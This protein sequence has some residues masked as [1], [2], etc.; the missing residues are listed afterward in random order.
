MSAPITPIDLSGGWADVSALLQLLKDP[1]ASQ[2]KLD[3]LV[4][5][6]NATK[7]RIAELHAM[8]AET[9]RLHNTAKATNIV[10]ENRKAALDA[11]E[12]E[13]E[14]RATQ[15]EQSESRH[16]AAS[17]QRRENLIEARE[18]AVKAE[19]ER[20]AVLRKDYEAKLG[21]LKTVLEG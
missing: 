13:I 15:L 6:E 11:R 18:N 3:E 10:S 1:A 21:K 14:Q 9:L 5:Q 2:Q 7:D 19:T 12:T 4:A 20:L 16:S 17:L 8:E